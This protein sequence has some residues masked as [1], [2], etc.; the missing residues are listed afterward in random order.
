MKT[1]LFEA[2]AIL[3]DGQA[4]E[5]AGIEESL[6]I[7]RFQFKLLEPVR[8]A[9]HGHPEKR[10]LRDSWRKEVRLGGRHSQGVS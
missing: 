3:M 8:I 4:K 2:F 7:S 6:L 9:R 1:A 10:L 5:V